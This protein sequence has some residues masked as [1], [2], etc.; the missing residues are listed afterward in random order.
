MNSHD[1]TKNNKSPELVVLSGDTNNENQSQTE[2]SYETVQERRL[3]H[4]SQIH[5]TL[6][7]RHPI[8]SPT[9]S[10]F[11]FGDEKVDRFMKSDTCN[12]PNEVLS[13][14][15]PVTIDIPPDSTESIGK[16]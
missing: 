9:L 13:D 2:A 16:N 15:Q 10:N 12:E 11:F 8:G 7:Y 1:Q 6:R 4:F 5:K 14:Q 3:R